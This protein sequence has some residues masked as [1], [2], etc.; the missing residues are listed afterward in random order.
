MRSMFAV[1]VGLALLAPS[2]AS[3]LNLAGQARESSLVQQWS[4]ELSGA[5]GPSPIKRVISLLEK[6]RSELEHEAQNEAE[7][8]DKMVCWCETYEKEKPK[9]IADAEVTDKE[10]TAEIGARAAKFG[11]D[12]T[13]IARLKEQI[14][15][16]TASLKE[17]TSIREADAAKFY[18]SNK[19][20]V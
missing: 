2:S 7:M 12:E 4:Q 16:D 11:E 17:A 5:E 13:E 20:L 8:Y 15:A 14:A 9:A 1:C 6:M 3:T 18:E 19:D 10:L